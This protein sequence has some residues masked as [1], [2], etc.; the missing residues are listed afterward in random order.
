MSVQ[1]LKTDDDSVHE[2]IYDVS[3]QDTSEEVKR[4]AE[5]YNMTDH[6]P[7]LQKAALLVHGT[8]P[9][10]VLGLTEE[11]M[12]ALREEIERKW[13]QPKTLYFTILVC[14]LGAIVQGW[15]QT[16]ANGAN[17]SFPLAFGIG[18][19]SEHDNLVVGLIN[20]GPYIATGFLYVW[21]PTLWPQSYG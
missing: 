18:S 19:D 11:D 15:A 13:K 7:V 14:S 16:G 2:A 8:A 3:K 20:S 10:H 6:L 12:L 21:G 17:L 5:S 4:F 9:E 1:T